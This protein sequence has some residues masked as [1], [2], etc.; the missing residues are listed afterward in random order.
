LKKKEHVDIDRH[1]GFRCILDKQFDND[2]KR[3]AHKSYCFRL[4]VED[5]MKGL[6]HGKNQPKGSVLTKAEKET[7][8]KD[9]RNVAFRECS[10]CVLCAIKS[11]MILY[12][13][14]HSLRG[15]LLLFR[16]R[17]GRT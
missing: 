9:S 5:N 17:C 11:E 16:Q 7:Y 4:E 8:A 1:K 15:M 2:E 13:M 3:P 6:N 14:P 12:F 10:L